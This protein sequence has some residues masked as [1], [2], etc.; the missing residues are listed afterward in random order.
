MDYTELTKAFGAFFAIMN[1]FVNLPVFLALTEGYSVADQRR[2]A[3]RITVYCAVMS[4]IILVAGN[5]IITFFGVTVD[6]FRIAGGIVL[7]S[8]AWS[9]LQ[10]QKI[11]AHHGSTDEQ[12]HLNTLSSLAFYPITF[13]MLVG[14]GTIAT[15]IIYG[16]N[17]SGVLDIAGIAAVVG[18]II[19]M[20]FVVMFFAASIS[21]VMTD[22][23][24]V[25]MTRLMGMILLAIA[26]EMI[27]A[28]VKVVLPGLG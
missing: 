12:D 23:M 22:T 24:R 18:M 13:P 16:G 14:P 15:L 9:M 7:A 4:A 11:A 21:K 28:G 6:Q 2:L 26:V 19:L 27:V 5:Q 3:I 8:I 10:G 1:P 20:L 25:I 17:A